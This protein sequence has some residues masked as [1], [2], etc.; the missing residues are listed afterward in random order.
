MRRALLSPAA[1]ALTSA[2]LV[3][4]PAALAQGP[5]VKGSVTGSL[6]ERSR[7][8]FRVTAT[9][10]D[11]WRALRTVTLILS[12]RGAPLEELVYEVDTTTLV[13]GPFTAL[14]GTGDD[15]TGRF[16]GVSALDVRVATAGDQLDL[17]FR[18][19]LLEDVP[20]GARF[21]FVAED[22]EGLEA[23]MARVAAV[24]EEEG[25]FPWATVIGAAVVALLAGG[26]LGSRLAP[27]RRTSGRSIY[28][29]VARK[30]L[31]ERERGGS[32]GAGR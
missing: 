25:S 10:P 2:L 22:D 16:L 31:E 15:V 18:A 17:S 32:Q 12:L 24:P 11:G 28:Q 8:A 9:H 3:A 20:P 30:I 21:E 6:T 7:V 29:D 5:S 26:F 14:L 1:L 19:R 27:H 4:G 13:A 23:R